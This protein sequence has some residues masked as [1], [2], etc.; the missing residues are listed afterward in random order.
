MRSL[1][2][3]SFILT[4]SGNNN[5][6]AH[7]DQ[8]QPADQRLMMEVITGQLQMLMHQMANIQ[9]EM[10]EMR[11]EREPR[12]NEGRR[13]QVAP[14]QQRAQPWQ[15]RNGEEEYEENDYDEGGP[16]KKM[17]MMKVVPIEGDL[18][19]VVGIIEGKMATLEASSRRFPNSKAAM[20]PKHTWGGKRG[21][22]T[23]STSTTIPIE[24][25]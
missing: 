19:K 3:L 1:F 13:N 10:G 21:S 2:L 12:A 5:D 14:R 11:V 15:R 16:E 6:G 9:E 24:R 20:I 7:E 4:M 23:F 17:T 25:R 22:R 8:N 18:S